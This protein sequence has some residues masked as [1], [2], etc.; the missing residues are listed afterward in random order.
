MAIKAARPMI[1]EL[2]PEEYAG[3]FAVDLSLDTMAPFTRN[4]ARAPGRRE[5]SP[6]R[7][8]PSVSARCRRLAWPKPTDPLETA[9]S[10]EDRQFAG[11]RVRLQAGLESPH[12]QAMQATSLATLVTMLSRFPG[13]KS[14]ILFSEGLAVSPRMDGVLPLAQDGN[15]T[16]YTLD[17]TG[18]SAAGRKVAAAPRN[19]SVGAHRIEPMPP[20]LVAEGIS[21]DGS[22]GGAGAAGGSHRRVLRERHQRSDRRRCRPSPRTA[23][24]STCLRT[25]REGKTVTTRPATWRCE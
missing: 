24:P 8:P 16:F 5:S 12:Q 6:G 3:V 9:R 23:A 10:P 25:R 11:M 18:L 15:V 17:A 7:G 19:R 13:R 4:K 22:H 21:R 2:A 14:V 20:S 1:D